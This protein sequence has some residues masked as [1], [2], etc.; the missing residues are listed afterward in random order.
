VSL[1]L[2]ITQTIAREEELRIARDT[3]QAADR[4]KSA[5]LARM[6]HE[7]RTPMNGVVGMADLLLER[8]LDDEAQLYSETIRNSGRALLDI[9][10]NILDFSK[11][12]AEKLTLRE[13]LFDLEQ[14]AQ[15]VCM[16]VTPSL[17][18][19]Q[20]ELLI[21]YDQ[22]LPTQQVMLN[23]VGN[24]IKFTECGTI[25][26]RFVGIE[27]ENSSTSSGSSTRSRM[28]QTA[29]LRA[30]GLGSL[31]PKSWWRPWAG[32]SGS[33]ASRIMARVLACGSP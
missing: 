13:E 11:L 30:Q 2:N 20:V 28:A 26:L 19:K 9:I 10:N 23:L 6:S 3:A 22:F 31:S 24:A 14:L 7:L 18:D 16:I 8:Q 12:E 33:T 15:E 17:R 29:G 27:A 25:M 5:F 4:A 32:R 21:D 1:A